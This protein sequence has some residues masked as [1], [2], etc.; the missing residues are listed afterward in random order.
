MLRSLALLLLLPSVVNAQALSPLAPPIAVAKPARAVPPPP[1]AA[2]PAP[3][4]FSPPTK[5][6]SAPRPVLGRASSWTPPAP[7]FPASR[8]SFDRTYKALF[9]LWA[10]G[11][12]GD[13]YTTWKALER[14]P[15][16]REGNRLLQTDDGREHPN[17]GVI[18]AGKLS[19]G[20]LSLAFE[21]MGMHR[22][23]R[24]LLWGGIAGTSAAIPLNT[25]I[26]RDGRRQ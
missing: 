14:C 25:T 4:F 10:A 17:Y 1:A 12:V 6:L 9:A 2:L 23:S 24:G 11:Q 3:V 15:P 13:G 20:A 7:Q 16:C 26:G 5:P 8:R 22:L 18:L 21:K 19:V